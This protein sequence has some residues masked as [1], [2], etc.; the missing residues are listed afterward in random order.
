MSVKI[1]NLEIFWKGAGYRVLRNY[2]T[3]RR[4]VVFEVRVVFEH[5]KKG[6]IEFQSEWDKIKNVAARQSFY[7]I[8]I[9]VEKVGGFDVGT[10]LLVKKDSISKAV[11][12]WSYVLKKLEGSYWNILSDVEMTD[13]IRVG[14][15]IAINNINLHNSIKA[16][17]T[18]SI[19]YNRSDYS[20]MYDK[21]LSNKE[22]TLAFCEGLEKHHK[23]TDSTKEVIEKLGN[24]YEEGEWDNE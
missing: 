11:T 1:K 16:L 3:E 4:G 6:S 17:S 12:Y 19:A 21:W 24:L 23:I 7:A 22:R 9:L 13:M 10:V 14:R 2:I 15:S 18:K 20:R 5:V 8:P